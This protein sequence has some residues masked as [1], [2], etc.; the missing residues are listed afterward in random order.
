ML[1]T[2][3]FSVLS[4]QSQDLE[5]PDHVSYSS[6]SSRPFHPGP[7]YCEPTGT[8]PVVR[9]AQWLREPGQTPL[10][11]FGDVGFFSR[12]ISLRLKW[13]HVEMYQDHWYEHKTEKDQIT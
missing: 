5:S 9:R 3:A 12:I 6:D 2:G 10:S 7:L 13:F 4:A 11:H 8:A 1:A